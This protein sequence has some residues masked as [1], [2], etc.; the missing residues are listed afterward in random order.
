MCIFKF[1]KKRLLIYY[2]NGI[3]NFAYNNSVLLKFKNNKPSE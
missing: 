2:L 1:N 3:F